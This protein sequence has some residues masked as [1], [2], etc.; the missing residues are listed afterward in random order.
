MSQTGL[1]QPLLSAT[2]SIN[3]G[4]LQ[5]QSDTQQGQAIAGIIYRGIFNSKL[6]ATTQLMD[7]CDGVI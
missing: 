2:P 3:A 6:A 1:T 5:I 7:G 4:G